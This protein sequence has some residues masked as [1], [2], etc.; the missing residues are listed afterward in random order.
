MQMEVDIDAKLPKLEKQGKLR[1]LKSISKLGMITY[2]MLGFSGDST[3]KKEVIARYLQS[4]SDARDNGALA[5]SPTNYKFR[6]KATL[7]SNGRRTHIFEIKPRK[8]IVGLFEGELWLDEE[9]GMPVKEAGRFVKNPSMF[10]K[11]IEFVRVYEIREGV[12]YPTHIQS[13]AEVR[14]FGKAELNIDFS[15]FT[16]SEPADAEQEAPEKVQEDVL[17]RYHSSADAQQKALLSVAMEVEVQG[18]YPKLH[19]QARLRVQRNVSPRGAVSYRELDYSGDSAFREVLLEIV[20]KVDVEGHDLLVPMLSADNYTFKEK[21]VMDYYGRKTHVFEFKPKNKGSVMA[22]Q[23]ELWLDAQTAMPVREFGKYLKSPS[24]FVKNLEY[25]RDFE[26]RGG[27]AYPKSSQNTAE[28]RTVGKAQVAL[29]FSN[30]TK[31]DNSALVAV[32]AYLQ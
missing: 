27:V 15:N 24:M 22:V 14:M 1:A 28:I 23:G 16:R 7:E 20:P 19:K 13:T 25:V 21:A 26:I 6:E 11:K 30:F 3:I 17:S 10:L 8:K 31:S 4:D 2:K 5:I 29:S 18:N 32:S 9:T 12:S